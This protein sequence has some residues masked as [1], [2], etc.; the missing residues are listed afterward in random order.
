MRGRGLALRG[1]AQMTVAPTLPR[2]ETSL[3]CTA[4]FGVVLPRCFSN[5]DTAGLLPREGRKIKAQKNNGGVG[6][7]VIMAHCL[8]VMFFRMPSCVLLMADLVWPPLMPLV[9]C[10]NA[11]AA[12]A[13]AASS[14][15]P[16]THTASG[17]A[18]R[19]APWY[20]RFFSSRAPPRRGRCSNDAGCSLHRWSISNESVLPAL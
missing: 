19:S 17:L 20:F 6:R 11:H 8:R 9:R 7:G 5:R 15:L 2:G 18:S 13:A 12:V 3:P 16:H 10:P 1:S 14:P 4:D